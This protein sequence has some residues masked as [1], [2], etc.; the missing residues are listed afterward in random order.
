[1]TFIRYARY[2]HTLTAVD[3]DQDG[4]DDIML[5]MGGY[6]SSP[7]NDVWVSETGTDWL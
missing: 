1:M 7:S 6:A 4:E 3:L 2:G 5:L